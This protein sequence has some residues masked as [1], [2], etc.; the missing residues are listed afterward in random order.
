MFED[1]QMIA[2]FDAAISPFMR[3]LDTM[4]RSVDKFQR[5]SRVGF[6]EVETRADRAG[7][8]I[9]ALRN[10]AVALGAVSAVAGIIRLGDEAKA[11]ENQMRGIG[12]AGKET[13]D[14]I[15]ALA[16]E[17]R[18]PI[19][20][21]V[22]LLT[23]MKKSLQDQP[24][25]KT[26]RQVGTLNR[27][28]TIG[29]LDGNARASVGL[30]FGQALQS[31]VLQGDELRSLR[32]AAPFELLEAIAEAAGGTVE[33]LRDLG[34]QGKLTRDVMVEALDELE[35][36]SR[37]RFGEF[38]M[39]VAE[40]TEAMRTGLI[41]VAGGVSAGLGAAEALAGMQQS[42]AK[43]MLENAE[44]GE[45]LG[46]AL[47]MV[48]E[49]ALTL[50]GARGLMAAT[51]ALSAFTIGTTVA[52]R[53][54][55]ILGLRATAT[56][57][58]LRALRTGL[59]IFGG[60]VGLA[61]FAAG[62]AFLA[63]SRNVETSADR[64]QSL[65]T[66]IEGLEGSSATIGRLQDELAAD[67]ERLEKVNRDIEKAI[68]DQ[69]TA[70]E[71]TAR[72]EGEAI[73]RRI[74]SNQALLA[75]QQQIRDE[76][77]ADALDA[78]DETNA[79]LADDARKILERQ[80]L[81]RIAN[82]ERPGA[83][84]QTFRGEIA[85]I[86]DEDAMARAQ[87]YLRA[88]DR[89]TD[90]QMTFLVNLEASIREEARLR[91]ELN[92][93]RSDATDAAEKEADAQA[94][95]DRKALGEYKNN[96]AKLTELIKA[97]DAAVAAL[98]R[99]KE[100][101]DQGEVGKFAEAVRLAQDELEG[102][103][104]S[105]KGATGRLDAMDSALDELMALLDGP[106][107]DFGSEELGT[108]GDMA[109]VYKERIEEAREKIVDLDAEDLDTLQGAVAGLIGMF[110]GVIERLGIVK[111]RMAE[112]FSAADVYGQYGESR[113]QGQWLAM[114]EGLSAAKAIIRDMEGFREKA[115]WD[116]NHWRAG[117]GSDTFTNG[118]G[119]VGTVQKGSTVSRAQAEADLD[120]RIQGYFET[121]IRM[122]GNDRFA[123]L[124]GP[125]QGAMAS[126]LHNYGAGEL[127]PGG[128]LGGV[129]NALKTGT[130]QA[131]AGEIAKLASHNGGVNKSRR[132]DE[133][134]AFGGAGAGVMSQLATV[135]DAQERAADATK[136]AA[137]EA[138]RALQTEADARTAYNESLA[139]TA[140][141]RELELSLIGQTA[142]EQA[143][144]IT[145]FEL[146]NDAKRRGID[147]DEV[148][149]GSN[150]TYREAI[151][152]QAEA[153]GRMVEVQERL[154]RSKEIA[155]ERDQFLTGAVNN[156]KDGL[157]D[158]IIEGQN[159]ASVL[160]NVAKMLAK[161]Y[162][163]AMLFGEGPFAGSGSGSGLLGG[164][165][166]GLKS[167][168]SANG[169][170]VSADGAH[171]LPRRAYAMGG[172]ASSPQVSIFGEGDTPEAYVP[173]P[174]GRTI[175]VTLRA[176]D[177]GRLNSHG[178]R[179]QPPSQVQVLGGDLVLSDNG[180]VM[181]RVQVVSVE[182]SK[183]VTE[184]NNQNLIQRQR[185]S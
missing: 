117:Y 65:S 120:R 4:D 93:V 103:Q 162:L 64:V 168:F 67:G 100:R 30:Q 70:A 22:G 36:T 56:A 42:M 137:D 72:L 15:Y 73:Q 111:D 177:V 68:K 51:T 110:D 83:T 173:L 34:S 147:L 132:L 74:E 84:F 155:A 21:T 131:V 63:L 17:T 39:T 49:L 164:L 165:F 145:R 176:P 152:E 184:R 157:I 104:A 170:I 60:P 159:F 141:R 62:T 13:K 167:I 127:K 18:T 122:I 102:F 29:G 86:S 92:D 174:D 10:T 129:L 154:N 151:E 24:L 20:A 144:A 71:A 78:L 80:E 179:P 133:A 6:Q 99:A 112:G 87:A 105:A 59:A 35:A 33:E 76:Q 181:A 77:K 40:A 31:G 52:G 172:I 143:E 5:Q 3:K 7:R 160:Q 183:A 38:K 85:A 130:A 149:A 146:L 113:Q 43:W 88:Q 136:T 57:Y 48:A 163:Q 150:R 95:A 98:D 109:K 175:P 58:G 140:E 2:K 128:D 101:G 55:Q 44:A 156:L 182:T 115:Y 1:R 81:A 47:R 28:L 66:A 118:D 153:A 185:R 75:I 53:A 158:A 27:L 135:E 41:A 79:S 90:G 134:S 89:L 91:G 119:S 96:S 169:N 69:A 25:E 14:Q 139:E 126:L 148:M 125:Q 107:G 114:R 32:E 46:K 161:A 142:A 82:G 106:N 108:A 61:I 94:E 54:V 123:N 138:A 116:V 50:A 8:A 166:T 26:I 45:T 9:A 178:Y 180:T 121:L 23:R 16:I 171:H 97:R 19:E 124:T 11:L 12:A 37:A